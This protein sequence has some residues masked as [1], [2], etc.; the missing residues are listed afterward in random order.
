MTFS[1]QDHEYMA[2]AIQIAKKGF[3]TT[4]PNPN[5]GCVVVKGGQIIAQGWHKKAGTG[6]AEV[7]AFAQLS[8]QQA[9]G[10]TAYVTLEPCSHYGRTPPCAELLIKSQVARVVIGMT[11]PNP[12]VAGK[13]IRMLEQAGI[14]VDVGLLEQDARA[15]N[16]GFLS[17][18]EKKRPFVQVKLAASLDG[19]TALHNGESKWITGASARADVQKY[20]AQSCAILSTA[21]TVLADDAALNV[22]IEELTF[23]YPIDDINKQIRQPKRIILD[24]QNL[25]TAEHVKTLRLFATSSEVILVR[26][27]LSGDLLNNDFVGIE[28]IKQAQINYDDGFDL[29]QLLSFAAQ[30]EIN[31]LWV[32]AGATLAASFVEQELYDQLICYLAPKIMG[33]SGQEMLPIGPLDAMSQ[34]TDLNLQDV[35]QLGNDLK[36]IYTK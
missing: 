16:P 28:N 8:E 36:L 15:L 25:I 24:S 32:E 10:A 12:S 23:A 35:T 9:K 5:V 6:H 31:M 19:K 22:R 17:R 7:N 33:K 14:K 13:G 20:R 29:N 4:S 1:I 26:K 34:V 2:H 30:Q 18:M 27:Q 21:K 11:D 3:Y